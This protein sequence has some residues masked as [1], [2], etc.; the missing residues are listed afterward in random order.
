MGKILEALA[1]TRAEGE[2]PL[3]ALIETQV[4]HMVRGST[5][6]LITPSSSNEVPLMVDFLMQRG[7]RPIVVIV[8]PSTFG[9]INGSDQLIES[10]KL[11]EVPFRVIQNGKDLS[12]A[13]S[14]GYE[15]G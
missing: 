4:K 1:L 8:D 9:G 11:L 7:L 13:L 15:K 12:L 5:A 14:N 10:I 3:R 6:V 2:L